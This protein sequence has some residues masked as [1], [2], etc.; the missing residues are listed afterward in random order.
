MA[1]LYLISMLLAE[2]LAGTLVDPTAYPATAGEY[3]RGAVVT[4]NTTTLE[5]LQDERL[6]A[7]LQFAGSCGRILLV[8]V[9]PSIEAII[10]SDAACDGRFVLSVTASDDLGTRSLELA[11][12]P[13]PERATDA[14]LLSLLEKLDSG[15]LKL[16]HLILFWTGYWLIAVS[17]LLNS[18]T[19]IVG[20]GFS[21]AA[22]LLVPLI[23][24]PAV[25]RTL[26]AWAEVEADDRI[27]AFFSVE[28]DVSFHHGQFTSNLTRKRGSFDLNPTWGFSVHDNDVEVCNYG[29][30]N[31]V[32]GHLFWRGKLFAIPEIPP[33]TSWS[34]GDGRALD[35]SAMSTPE[36]TLYLKRSEQHELTFLRA[37]PVSD[38]DG[39]GWLLQY[40]HP[41]QELP[42]CE[43]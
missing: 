9:S 13:D 4:I 20:L 7:L 6:R 35:T 3:E 16:R 31:S 24:P 18:R 39:H 33:G 23:W 32:S 43:R 30:G 10:R 8:D 22:T 15:R 27:A 12:L 28:Q 5:S 41:D 38:S 21:L 40:A 42:S 26:V 36:L 19:R 14:E 25:S 34:S 2:A 1:A 11:N 17:L 29:T 37:L